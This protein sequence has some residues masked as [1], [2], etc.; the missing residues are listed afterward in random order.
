[1]K[2]DNKIFKEIVGMTL[3]NFNELFQEVPGAY[4]QK[5]RKAKKMGGNSADHDPLLASRVPSSS[6]LFH[7][8]P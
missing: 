7:F 8:H 2:A 1:L 4:N 5:I 6:T 3:S